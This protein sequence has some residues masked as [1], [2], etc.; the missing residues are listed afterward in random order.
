MH[1]NLDHATEVIHDSH[2]VDY[3]IAFCEQVSCCLK[4]IVNSMFTLKNREIPL[5]P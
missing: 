2:D 4:R 1:G 3:S 5:P